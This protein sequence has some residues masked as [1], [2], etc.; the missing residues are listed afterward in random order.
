[1][2]VKEIFENMEY[3]VAPEAAGDALAWIVDQGA[4][5]GH[6]IN[7]QFTDA[8]SGNTFDLINPTTEA[9]TTV[10]ARGDSADVDAAVTAARDAF[11]A[12]DW[13]RAKPA[14]RRQV[15]FKAA[16]QLEMGLRPILYEPIEKF[17]TSDHKPI[18]GAFD[19]LLNPKLQSTS[20]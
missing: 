15:L 8:A 1:M 20:T 18:R 19:I 4:A 13:S 6:F 2:T 11:D 12:G 3:G 5:F 16:D 9:R 10:A 14:F 17:T 7:G